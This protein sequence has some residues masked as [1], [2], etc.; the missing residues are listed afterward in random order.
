MTTDAL[1]TDLEH[2]EGKVTY[3]YQDSLGYWTIGVGHLID[4]RKGGSIP[5]EIVVALL[6]YDCAQ[7]AQELD[8]ALPWWRKLD[9]V[10]QDALLNMAFNL[11]VG[12]LL[13]FRH[14]LAALQAG[15]TTRRHRR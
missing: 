5:D 2:D 1:Y 10:R 13:N 11:G 4:H 8:H 6:K 12:G 7:K 3:A 15:S 14:F 9:D